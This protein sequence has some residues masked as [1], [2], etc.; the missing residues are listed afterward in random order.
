[1]RWF[2]SKTKHIS[3]VVGVALLALFDLT[4]SFLLMFWIKFTKSKKIKKYEY[5]FVFT[6]DIGDTVIFSMF[7]LVFYK[8]VNP[9]CIVI[10]SDI[11][12]RLIGPFFPET[13]FLI[14]D[15]LKYKTS[16][17][18]RFLKIKEIMNVSLGRCIAPMRSRDYCVTDSIVKTIIKK[19]SLAFVSDNSN[20]DK[21]EAYI[22]RFVYD[23]LI[24]NFSASSHELLSYQKLLNKFKLDFQLELAE[25]ILS[26]RKKAVEALIPLSDDFPR[27]YVL[28]NVGASQMYKRW[29]IEKFISL[30]EKIYA[31]LRL[32][33]VFIGGPSEKDLQG[34]FA[35][36]PFIIDFV[37]K[38]ESFEI[39]RGVIFNA[40]LVVSNDTFVGHY[41]VMLGTPTINI[42]G[43]GHFGR[44]LP[45]PKD[46]YP[47]FSN[48]Y[49]VFKP[50]L[51][52]NCKWACTE[53]TNASSNSPFPC[54]NKVS[55][56]DVFAALGEM[57]NINLVI[58]G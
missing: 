43:G 9:N 56:E 52:F 47:M 5:G 21:F 11:N 40:R 12:A 50:L 32:V 4:S 16:L 29:P 48:S 31:E 37:M 17:L 1:M 45:Y 41:S 54:I 44:F 53:I 18:Y 6:S 7:F 36:Y 25:V 58:E 55:V 23:E 13:D 8:K 39:L 14:V 3:R 46:D 15:Y 38:T 22:E 33:S 57:S 51:C 27:N 20:R 19:M 10:T 35:Q 24:K 49:T 34:S 28:M 2:M 26:F 42:A 30:A